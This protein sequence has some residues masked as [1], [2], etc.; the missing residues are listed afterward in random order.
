MAGEKAQLV[1][2]AADMFGQVYGP[3]HPN[4]AACYRLLAH[5]F[6]QL[7]ELATA[8]AFQERAT[9]ISG[10]RSRARSTCALTP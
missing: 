9:R 8:I 5:I 4:I 3:L 6:G 7:D 2:E 1:E 10:L